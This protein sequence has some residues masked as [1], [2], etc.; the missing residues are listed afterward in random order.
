MEKP[1]L[2]IQKV[3]GAPK[4]DCIC[5]FFT[6]RLILADS[7][8]ATLVSVFFVRT[9]NHQDLQKLLSEVFELSISKIEEGNMNEGALSILSNAALKVAQFLGQEKVEASFL[10]TLFYKDAVYIARH[11]N[12]V[13]LVVFEP[14]SSQ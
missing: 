3:S 7:Q 12:S 11:G 13:K 5:Q 8:V 10:H 6:H 1:K 14:K 9:E 2:D 4:P